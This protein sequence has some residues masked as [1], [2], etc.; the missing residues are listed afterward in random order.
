MKKS[1]KIWLLTATALIIVGCA[2][3]GVVMS[4][5]K[6]NFAE[7]STSKYKTNKH[8]ISE[9][10]KN[11]SIA[12][13]TAD[14]EFLP[15]GNSKSSVVCYEEEKA[16]HKVAVKDD[17]LF[18]QLEETKKWYEYIGINFSTPKITVFIP[19][20]E[21]GAL[22]IESSTS[23]I[24][25]KDMSLDSI[26]VKVSTGD[27]LISNTNCK[28]NVN[29][30]VSTG[31]VLLLNALCKNVIT[32]GNTGDV[33]L[34]NVIAS[35]KFSIIRS[36]GDIE[37]DNSDANEIYIKTDTGDVEGSLLSEKI[38]ITETDTGD[39]E[40]PKTVSGG[41]CEII[42]NTGDIEIDIKGSLNQTIPM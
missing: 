41:K 17:T 36:T 30:K 9:N 10:F 31:K 40:V 37:L 14:I 1:T 35:E 29:I 28:N 5:L 12:S 7:F 25:I 15:S 19:K 2:V 33:D 20:N 13:D 38:F 8:E 26:N 4:C 32:E 22:S 23:D 11:I 16:R 27:V 21:F 34:N 6:W 39:I 24:Q 42:T 18:I 3:F